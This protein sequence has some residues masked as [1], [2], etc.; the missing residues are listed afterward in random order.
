MP[1]GGTLTIETRNIQV[2]DRTA[3]INPEISPG[4]YA[5]FSIKDTGHGMDRETM[6]RIFEPFFTTKEVGKGTG[7]GLATVYGI[8]MQSGGHIQVDSEPGHGTTFS[9]YLPRAQEEPSPPKKAAPAEITTLS[10]SAGTKTILLV[11]DSDIVRELT[12]NV[13][14]ISGYA[15]LEAS[16]PEDAIRLCESHG[17]EIHLLLTDVVMPG[18]SGRDL[19]DR[20]KRVRP[21]MK[22]LYMSGYTE[23]AIVEHGILDAGL[24]FIPK[25][26]SPASM[27]QKILEVLNSD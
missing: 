26:F 11:E 27:A 23:E 2:D 9:I 4:A 5:V 16:S 18:M 10:L 20:L 6:A 19:S 13:L 17:G 12:R 24:H 1:K 8:V 21:G 15:I 3:K 14:D 25:P 22:V 7:L